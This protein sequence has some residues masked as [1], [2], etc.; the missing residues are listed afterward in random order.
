MEEKFKK[1]MEEGIVMI[2]VKMLQNFSKYCA[3]KGVVIAGGALVI[4]GNT[5][6]NQWVYPL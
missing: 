6:D 1:L 5:I 4:S 2:P 3:S